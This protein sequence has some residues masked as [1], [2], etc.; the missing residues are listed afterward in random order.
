MS[1][2]TIGDKPLSSLLGGLWEETV[3]E[4]VIRKDHGFSVLDV[5]YHQGVSERTAQ[6]RVKEM[7]AARKIRVSGKRTVG[8]VNVD[9]FLPM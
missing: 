4:R 1:E 5:A 3:S 9:V 2:K 7:L 6:R 8:R